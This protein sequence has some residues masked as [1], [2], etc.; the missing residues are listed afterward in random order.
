MVT[1]F[2]APLPS[3]C[4]YAKHRDIWAKVWKLLPNTDNNL[5]SDIS[6]IQQSM[7]AAVTLHFFS[8]WQWTISTSP[9]WGT[10]FLPVWVFGYKSH[11]ENKNQAHLPRFVNFFPFAQVCCFTFKIESYLWQQGKRW[12]SKDKFIKSHTSAL[13]QFELYLGA[14]QARK[15]HQGRRG[16][17]PGKQG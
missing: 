9:V 17:H 13:L 4:Q 7:T 2:S 12:K 1:H 11:W 16:A 8:Q 3:I 14:A 10:W 5:L 6:H 15:Q